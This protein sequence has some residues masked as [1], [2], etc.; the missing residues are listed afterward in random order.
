MTLA[1]LI[2]ELANRTNFDIENVE[3]KKLVTNPTLSQIDVPIEYLNAIQSNLYNENEAKINPSLNNH[4]KKHY[5]GT[6]LN[7]V[8]SKISEILNKTNVSE[9]I[10]SNILNESNTYNK[11]NML[12]EILNSTQQSQQKSNTDNNEK[13]S[14]INKIE[15][16][17]QL[18]QFEQENREFYL[19]HINDDWNNKLMNKEIDSLFKSYNYAIDID[20]NI[21]ARTARELFEQ[22]LNENGGKY[23]Y[24][25]QGIKLVNKDTPDLPFTLNNKQVD[26]K[27]FAENILAEN[28]LL[29]INKSNDTIENKN[30]LENLTNYN[31]TIAPAAK[32]QT[33]KALADFMAGSRS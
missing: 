30:P 18:L 9:D 11:I 29:K 4:F 25:E 7:A 31:N 22:K 1:E 20:K 12:S 13:Q 10:K 19:Q 28:K 27:S 16:L 6:A 24:T 23:V 17:Q 2:Q 33:Q 3:L 21:T 15:E 14:L 5:I 8:D 26:I 32:S